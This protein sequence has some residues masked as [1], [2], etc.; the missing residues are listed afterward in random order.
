MPI[1]LLGQFL[2]S[3]DSQYFSLLV[4]NNLFKIWAIISLTDISISLSIS[5]LT[6]EI[7]LAT[8]NLIAFFS[9]DGPQ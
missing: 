8:M 7:I 5:T 2:V 1:I 9:Y 4:G 6:I 3:K